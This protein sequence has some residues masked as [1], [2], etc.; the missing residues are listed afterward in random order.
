VDGLIASLLELEQA[1]ALVRRGGELHYS[2]LY[3]MEVL[4]HE[5]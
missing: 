2:D 5:D 3:N 4:P 1:G